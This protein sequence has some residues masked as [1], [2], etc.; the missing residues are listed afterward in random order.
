MSM[1]TIRL[2]IPSDC[3]YIVMLLNDV[4]INFNNTKA[5]QHYCEKMRL[6]IT[7]TSKQGQLYLVQ[8]QR[9]DSSL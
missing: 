9:E 2:D 5:L 7:G 8:V 6:R 3:K 1:D 4:A